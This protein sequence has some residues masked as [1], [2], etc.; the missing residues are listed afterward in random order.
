MAARSDQRDDF[1]LRGDIGCTA[2]LNGTI[3]MVKLTH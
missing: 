1:P 3:N 2:T